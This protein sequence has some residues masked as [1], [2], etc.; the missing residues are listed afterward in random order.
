MQP[1]VTAEMNEELNRHFTTLNVHQALKEMH[2]TKPPWARWYACILLLEILPYYWLHSNTL[3][4]GCA[5]F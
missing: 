5:E 1:L 3:I 2:P 4:F